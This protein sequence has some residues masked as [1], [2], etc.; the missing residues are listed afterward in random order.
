[1]PLASIFV[2]ISLLV[3]LLSTFKTKV[4]SLPDALLFPNLK[5]YSPFLS[6]GI[7]TTSASKTSNNGTSTLCVPNE[8]TALSVDSKLSNDSKFSTRLL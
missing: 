6:S 1:M 2:V 8:S 7:L 5:V 4:A 3:V